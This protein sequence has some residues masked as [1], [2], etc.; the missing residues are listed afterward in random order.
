MIFFF[1]SVNSMFYVNF[2]GSM[3]T[4]FR[5]QN[6]GNNLPKHKMLLDILSLIFM[7]SNKIAVDGV[8]F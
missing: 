8:E 7:F 4:D 6:P 2:Q 3:S 1:N 5:K